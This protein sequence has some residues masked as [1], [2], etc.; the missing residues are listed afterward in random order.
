VKRNG[1]TFHG[2]SE[3]SVYE[4]C[5]CSEPHDGEPHVRPALDNSEVFIVGTEDHVPNYSY[6]YLSLW[7][8]ACA[9]GDNISP[10]THS[11]A[12]QSS[13]ATGDA[14]VDAPTITSCVASTVACIGDSLVTCG[15]DGTPTTIVTCNVGCDASGAA[16]VCDVL[17]PSNLAADLCDTN[18]ATDLGVQS[19]SMALSTDSGCD[20]VVAQASGASICVRKYAS[21]TIAAG[22][23]VRATGARALALVATSSFS[24]AG[25]IDVSADAAIAGPGAPLNAGNGGA[26]ATTATGGGGGGGGTAGAA[27][28]DA[29]SQTAGG[30]AGAMT[31][32]A[33]LIPLVAGSSG[34]QNG[35]LTNATTG[36]LGGGALQLVGC[37]TIAISASAIIDAGGSGGGGGAGSTSIFAPGGGG[38]GG[39]GGSILIESGSVTIAGVVAANGGGGG[40]GGARGVNALTTGDSGVAGGD[41]ATTASAAPGGTGTGAGGAGG[42]TTTPAVASAPATTAD[43]GG[44][45]G[46]AAGRVRVNTHAAATINGVTSPSASTGPVGSH[47]PS[48]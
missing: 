23:T 24:L 38:G 34:G 5:A 44:G 47:V 18:G 46:G 25:T 9:C 15:S 11:D 39:G 29:N 41:G 36:G 40:G 33:T 6:R 42:A 31:G 43:A 45:G 30:A 35:A 26:G 4:P 10:A 12:T 2:V 3:A 14:G 13:D 8:F 22:A 17:T 32:S 21:I 19:G 20:A 37:Q 27:G 1:F 28:A 48:H 7:L 16:P